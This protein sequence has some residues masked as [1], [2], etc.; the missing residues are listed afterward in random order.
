MNEPTTRRQWTGFVALV[1]GLILAVLITFAV[2]LAF[3]TQTCAC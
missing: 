2:A 1:V 3:A